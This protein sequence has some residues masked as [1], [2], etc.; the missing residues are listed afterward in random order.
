MH[1]NSPTYGLRY[2]LRS[3]VAPLVPFSFQSARGAH[4]ATPALPTPRTPSQRD[5]DRYPLLLRVTIVS[6]KN[7]HGDML[8][9]AH[10]FEARHR[11]IY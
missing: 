6:E 10:P 7:L 4:P 3:V 8:R 11:A 9:V 2:H 5:P 1:V